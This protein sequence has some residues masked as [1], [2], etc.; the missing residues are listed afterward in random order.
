MTCSGFAQYK[1]PNGWCCGGAVPVRSKY[2]RC[3][4]EV[5]SRYAGSTLKGHG[6]V[7]A[8]RTLLLQIHSLASNIRLLWLGE[9]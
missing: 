3:A 9:I 5:R 2:A 7:A 4:L 8:L 6:A 1:V